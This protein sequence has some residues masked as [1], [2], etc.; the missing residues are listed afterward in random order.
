MGLSSVVP[1]NI[2]LQSTTLTREGFGTLLI[3]DYHQRT[4]GDLVSDYTSLKAMTDEGFLTT[5][6]AYRA[7]Q[8]AFAQNPRPAKV[9]IGR[10]T[11]SSTQVSELTPATAAATRYAGQLAFQGGSY[12]DWEFTSS[13]TANT[14][15]I[16]EGI[17]AAIDGLDNANATAATASG[18]RVIVSASGA[19]AWHSFAGLSRTFSNFEDTTADNGIADD[20]ADIEQETTDY[21]GVIATSKGEAEILALSNAVEARRKFYVAA[22]MD[23]TAYASSATTDVASQLKTANNFRTATL[24]VKGKHMDQ[25]DAAVM[26]MWLPYPAGSETVH[27]KSLRSVDTDRF[28]DTEFTNLTNKN[29]LFFTY[30]GNASA[31]YWGKAASGE[32]MDQVRFVDWLYNALQVDVTAKM[33]TTPGKVPFTDAGID[34]IVRT[35]QSTLLRGVAVG[36]LSPD[37]PPTVTAPSA[38]EIDPLDKAARKLTPLEFEAVAAGAIHIVEINGSISV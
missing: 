28:T 11:R 32:Y 10:R 9:R 36:G 38:A 3:L 8:K 4:S 34:S 23:K 27:L 29:A 19:G 21:Y 25:P 1:L 35:V 24:V 6:L 5:D 14:A 13:A 37:T 30:L 15:E 17:K 7:A 33:Q 18:G 26:G 16:I 12:Q 31:L 22:T 20:L 2:V